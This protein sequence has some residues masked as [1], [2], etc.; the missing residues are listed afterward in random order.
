[1][2]PKRSKRAAPADNAIAPNSVIAAMEP[3]PVPQNVPSIR[4]PLRCLQ[5]GTEKQDRAN[6][7][8]E[9]G[10]RFTSCTGC[11]HTTFATAKSCHNCGQPTTNKGQ[12][13]RAK[14][15]ATAVPQAP[16]Q[17]NGNGC[18]RFE[19][20]IRRGDTL[21]WVRCW[22]Q[23]HH[24]NQAQSTPAMQHQ[25]LASHAQFGLALSRAGPWPGLA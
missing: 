20:R 5:C 25:E 11:G 19:E 12:A 14:E 3:A 13:T 9:C 1:M 10:E 2:P 8:T 24:R 7:C 23:W 18:G 17:G 21:T 4:A 16:V 15:E 6:F 22:Q